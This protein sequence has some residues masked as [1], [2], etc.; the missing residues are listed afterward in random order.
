[1]PELVAEVVALADRAG[2]VCLQLVGHDWGGA[3][4]WQLAARQPEGVATCTAVSTPTGVSWRPP[5]G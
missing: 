1:M 4:A 3:V 2:V 5:W